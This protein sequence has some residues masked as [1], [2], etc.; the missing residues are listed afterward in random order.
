MIS[1]SLA[2]LGQRTAPVASLKPRFDI[3]AMI[4]PAR[5]TLKKSLFVGCFG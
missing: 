4:S 5:E 1:V 2:E 3:Y